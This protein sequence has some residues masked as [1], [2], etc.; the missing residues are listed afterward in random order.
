MM[1]VGGYVVEEGV[2]LSVADRCVCACTHLLQSHAVLK[3][4]PPCALR[5]RLSCLISPNLSV[6]A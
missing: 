1:R 3:R 6:T 2:F 5:W 4:C